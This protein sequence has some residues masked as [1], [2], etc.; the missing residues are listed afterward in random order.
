MSTGYRRA[1]LC[2]GCHRCVSVSRRFP[3]SSSSCHPSSCSLFLLHVVF[4]TWFPL[5]HFSSPSLPSF[6]SSLASSYPCS[7]SLPS[8]SSYHLSFMSFPCRRCRCLPSLPPPC[9][10]LL[11]PPSLYVFTFLL[12]LVV[13]LPSSSSPCSSPRCVAV[14]PPPP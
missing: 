4:F 13:P 1:V 10:L 8:S 7:S 3:P 14:I 12:L 9:P 6:S 2:I 5:L 11:L